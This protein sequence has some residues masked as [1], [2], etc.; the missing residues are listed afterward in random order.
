[1]SDTKTIAQQFLDALA[2]NDAATYE[3]ILHPSVG[4]RLW[5]WRGSESHRPRARVMKRLMDEWTAWP[6]ATLETHTLIAEEPRVA[7]EFRIQATERGQYVEHNRT[8]MLQIKDGQVHVIDLYCAEPVPSLR[9]KNW[10]APAHVSE[11]ALHQLFATYHHMN[12][13][14]ERISAS[15]SG[16]RSLRYVQSGS[17]LAHPAS[18]EI[19]GVRW[20][21]EETD[22]RITALI[23]WHRQRNIGFVWSVTP[24][25]TPS[26]LR[27]RL[28]RH[29]FVLAG[30]QA[31]MARVGLDNLDD[32]ATNP[33]VTVEVVDGTN[34]DALEACLQI[35]G[36]CFNMTK[37]QIDH[38]RPSMFERRKDP[39]INVWDVTYLAR[40]YGKPIANARVVYRA[41][42]AYLGGAATLSQYRNQKVYATLLHHRLEDARARG[43]HVSFIHAEPMSRRVV[44]RYGFKEYARFHLYGWMPEMDMEVIKAIVPDE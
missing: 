10:I 3:K 27:K 4:L 40:W 28:E 15:H 34:D 39:A 9:R 11:A 16:F 31:V 33:A 2:A 32:I 22:A 44:A 29:G 6:D 23:E 17:G 38:W 21:A 1:M 24:Y 25:D 8:A 26:D 35:T 18:N 37:E 7:I 36:R 42:V 19:E 43:Y 14:R 30:D 5:G 13:W 20:T 12:D 41:G